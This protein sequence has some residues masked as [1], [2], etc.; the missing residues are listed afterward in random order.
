MSN[1]KKVNYDCAKQALDELKRNPT[2]NGAYILAVQMAE[3]EAFNIKNW[4]I[5]VEELGSQWH[6][7]NAR[8]SKG[9]EFLDNY[10]Y[11]ISPKYFNLCLKKFNTLLSDREKLESR[12]KEISEYLTLFTGHKAYSNNFANQP[13]LEL[14]A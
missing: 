13:K 14:A 5:E 9:V 12:Y 8:I 7:I 4:E 1:I 3:K 10:Q 11:V 2:N 6:A